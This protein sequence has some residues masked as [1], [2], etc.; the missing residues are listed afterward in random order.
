MLGLGI[1][2]LVVAAQNPFALLFVLPSLHAWLWLP[3]ASDRG[4]PA[5]LFVY[6]LGFIGPALLL[7]S[8]ALRFHLGFDAMWYLLALTSIGYVPVALV[9]SLLVWTAAAAQVGAVAT[10]RY[11]PYPEAH[12]RP[13]RGLI[14]EGIRQVI[15]LNRR[16]RSERAKKTEPAED[17]Q[18]LDE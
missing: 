15:F 14:R 6:A 5:A 2:A 3:H 11:A 16:L 18:A 7:G 17:A 9:L 10:G 13:K 1:V 4:R 8:F 12:E